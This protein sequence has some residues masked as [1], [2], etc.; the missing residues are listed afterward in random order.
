[1][2]TENLATSN[3]RPRLE[4]LGGVQLGADVTLSDLCQHYDAVVLA[5]GAQKEKRL[6]VLGEDAFANQN[7]YPSMTWTGWLNGYQHYKHAIPTLN[8]NGLFDEAIA[9][10]AILFGHGNVA[11]DVARLLLMPSTELAPTD[12]TVQA[13]STLRETSIRH[14]NLIGRRGPAQVNFTSA[15]LREIFKLSHSQNFPIFTNRLELLQELTHQLS[16]KEPR[17]A[18][19]LAKIFANTRIQQLD[20][21]N[22]DLTK[23]FGCKQSLTLSFLLSPKAFLPN[24]AHPNFASAVE[25][26]RNEFLPSQ[27]DAIPIKSCGVREI[28][29]DRVTFKAA[30]FVKCIGFSIGLIPSLPATHQCPATGLIK[31]DKG[32]VIPPSLEAALPNNN[33]FVTGWCKNGATGELASTML[34][35]YE[36]AASVADFISKPSHT[37]MTRPEEVGRDWLMANLEKQNTNYILF[38]DWHAIDK[39]EIA[40]GQKL[41]K[42]REKIV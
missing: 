8:Y 13:L 2:Q 14:V 10:K 28:P 34:C 33:L 22:V 26:T 27:N 18:H 31:N 24:E 4:W 36:T 32:H 3:K 6:N 25:C 29:G 21:W 30:L 15:E 19:S 7:I 20:D 40:L 41:F 17:L 9:S 39:Q 35:A 23:T 38:K 12:I 11:L 1:M 5:I 16:P 42:S 37:R